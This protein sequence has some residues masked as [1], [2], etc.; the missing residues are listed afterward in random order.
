[1]GNAKS[2]HES[3]VKPTFSGPHPVSSTVTHNVGEGHSIQ[4]AP[5][6]HRV[7]PTREEYNRAVSDFNKKLQDQNWIGPNTTSDSYKL[8][9]KMDSILIEGVLPP[10]TGDTSTW[11]DDSSTAQISALPRASGILSNENIKARTLDMQNS[12]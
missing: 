11:V 2:S 5:N 9:E 1:M 12:Y 6:M 3:S 8:A 10:V 7:L 4:H